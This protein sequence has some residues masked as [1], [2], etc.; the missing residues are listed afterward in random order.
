MRNLHGL[1]L[2]DF[3]DVKKPKEKKEIYKTLYESMR[4]DK[5]KHTILP[6]SKFGIIEMTRQKRG[7]KISNIIGEKCLVC[8]G[9]GLSKIKYQYVMK[10]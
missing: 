4:S 3:I 1:I 2:I 5:S 6:M 9:Y 10:F 7:S 8:N